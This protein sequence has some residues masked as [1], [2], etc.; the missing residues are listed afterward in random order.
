MRCP[1]CSKEIEDQSRFCGYCGASLEPASEGPPPQEE[2][3]PP[4]EEIAAEPAAPVESP[5]PVEKTQKKKKRTGLKVLLFFSLLAVVAGTVLGYI[6]GRG[7]V[8][9]RSYLPGQRFT[10]TDRSEGVRTVDILP[11]AEEPDEKEKRDPD[12]GD[13]GGEQEAVTDLL[14]D[15]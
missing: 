11:E 4:P 14:T 9:W 7:I 12:E 13:A 3:P 1:K 5:A 15:P 8:D 10:W 2:A 6:V